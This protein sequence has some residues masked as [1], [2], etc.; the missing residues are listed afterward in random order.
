MGTLVQCKEAHL[1]IRHY[2]KAVVP[3]NVV[4]SLSSLEI[5][6]EQCRE[7]ENNVKQEKKMI[8]FWPIYLEIVKRLC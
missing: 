2:S 7:A 4:A 8:L 1:S 6:I 3:C 5:T